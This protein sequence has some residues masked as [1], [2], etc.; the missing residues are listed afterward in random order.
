MELLAAASGESSG[1]FI[2]LGIAVIGLAI[3][4]RIASKLGFSAIPLYLL[5]GLAFGNGGILPVQFSESFVRVG[6]EVGVVLLL[7]MLGLEYTGEKLLDALRTG[8][9]TAG[10]D[11]ILNFLPGFLAA[12]LLGMSPLAAVIL[13]G[14][15]T[16]S[17]SGIVS[18]ILG[19]SGGPQTPGVGMVVKV[20]VL[21]DLAMAIYLPVIAVL[22]S[23][24][25]P[26]VAAVSVLVA[27]LTV[28]LILFV[29]VRFGR[30]MSRFVANQSDEVVL[31]ST[32]GVILLVSGLASALH[33][34]AAVGAFL[35]G[36]A[37]SGPLADRAERQIAPLRDLFSA[38]FFLFFGLQIDPHSLPT[39]LPAAAALALAGAGTKV[40][41]G[42]LVGRI[43]GEPTK[44]G[45]KAGV[46]LIPR[47][48]F[49]MVI[50]G[51]GVAIEPRL[52]PL[53]AAYVLILAV[54]GPLAARW[55]GVTSR[56]VVQNRSHRG[57]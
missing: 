42:W 28:A 22:L 3:L 11:L 34:S 26:S 13:G 41:T 17:S 6:A 36:V 40:L 57:G 53:A 15:T 16:I 50:A 39:M 20:L 24:E 54:G 30:R 9:P 14:L 4:A 55:W 46:T 12:L 5:A 33:V 32:L 38:T 23:G 19:E 35:V 56:P 2:E 25:S 47:G 44:F 37:V 48:E 45:L 21:E 18:K 52:G 31:L 49:S 27:I 10:I 1:V 51:L 8:L 29:A 43:D 7:F